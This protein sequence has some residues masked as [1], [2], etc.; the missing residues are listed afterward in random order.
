MP[1]VKVQRRR[2]SR[3]GALLTARRA[4]RGPRRTDDAQVARMWKGPSVV[5]ERRW[6]DV[7]RPAAIVK[8]RLLHRPRWTDVRLRAARLEGSS[9]T[10][11]SL[12]LAICVIATIAV[13]TALP[14]TLGGDV[15]P[16]T[17]QVVEGVAG[18]SLDGGAQ[19]PISGEE[20]SPPVVVL[21]PPRGV[22]ASPTRGASSDDDPRSRAIPLDGE[23]LLAG[24]T[25]AEAIDRRPTA[26]RSET[27][28]PLDDSRTDDSGSK[29][30]PG[31]SGGGS[32]QPDVTRENSGTDEDSDGGV[33]PSDSTDVDGEPTEA[34]EPDDGSGGAIDVVETESPEVLEPVEKRCGRR[35][36]DVKPCRSRGLDPADS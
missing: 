33:P 32:P 5:H 11:R 21:N 4:P 28:A 26:A 29:Q 12:G 13:T 14:V 35:V 27:A 36:K 24:E 8:D 34:P 20:S 19:V 1:W 6:P 2:R 25:E 10:S 9:T 15:R 16:D 7:L 17:S 22:V 23:G 31:S 3:F 18:S 30:P